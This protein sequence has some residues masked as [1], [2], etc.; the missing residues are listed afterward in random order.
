M[1]TPEQTRPVYRFAAFEVEPTTGEVRKSGIRIR[2][3]EQPLKLLTA[4]L[5]SPGALITREELHRRL[6]PEDTFVDFEHGL[7]AAATRLRHAL[8]DSAQNPRFIESVP[9]RG[10]R[11]IGQVECVERP[12]QASPPGKAM[13]ATAE[14]TPP[15]GSRLDDADV[16][17]TLRDSGNSVRRRRL[18]AALLWSCVVAVA[19]V[20][21]LYVVSMKRTTTADRRI[22]FPLEPPEETIFAEFDSMAVSPDGRLLT[23]TATDLSGAR[24][25]WVRALDS[26]RS[27]RLEETEGALFP[28]WSPDSRSIG[29]FVP[30]KLKRV[31]VSGGQP[32]ELC[33]APD[34]RGG[35]WNRSGVIVFAPATD[36]PLL[37]TSSTGSMPKPLTALDQSRHEI[38]HRW[39]VFLP[40]GNRFLYMTRSS[41]PENTGIYIA[42]LSSPHGSLLA[43][44]QSRAEVSCDRD[45]QAY[46][47]F[48]N[49]TSLLAQRFDIKRGTLAGEPFRVADDILHGQYI[50]PL[51]AAFATSEEGVL[52]YATNRSLDQ[53]TWFERDGARTGSVGE[54]GVHL[55]AS[56]APDGRAVAFSVRDPRTGKFGIWQMDLSRSTPS[57]LTFD[58]VDRTLP[59]WS[60]DGSRIAYGANVR[61]VFNM[62]ER[63]SIGA[64]MEAL[65]LKSDRFQIPT[66][67][68]PD[69]RV[70][71]YFEIAPDKKRDLWAF[72]LPAPEPHQ[73]LL[74]PNLTKRM[75]SSP[76]MGSGS[77][78]HRTSRGSRKS[79]SRRSRRRRAAASGK[80][81]I[82]A[83]LSLNGRVRATSCTTLL[84]TAKSWPSE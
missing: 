68:S 19:A 45:G 50:E 24:H 27:R 52:A 51:H 11:F 1:G 71:L 82:A 42:S 7:N 17:P 48:A 23:F 22:S 13:S 57:Q 18:P 33:E 28:F 60:P 5:E 6:W 14:S 73:P 65:I 31:D 37:Q 63:P 46:V 26:P 44:V 84:R 41:P 80:F 40:D 20:S 74:T 59:I 56:L 58:S 9:R 77:S 21:A 76:P 47:V 70:L 16:R 36:A 15:S 12:R 64:G 43:H 66:D 62:Y 69:G 53:L 29:F 81:R 2:I 54:A 4:L 30:G 10:Y 34:G 8:G 72:P 67:W 49:G 75:R 32:Q 39:P 83:V 38:T 78:T 25:L 61:G 35:T 55:G 79:M 3:Q